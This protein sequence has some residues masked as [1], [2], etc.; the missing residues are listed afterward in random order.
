MKSFFFFKQII[1]KIQLL[2]RITDFRKKREK[3]SKIKIKKKSSESPGRSGIVHRLRP[4]LGDD[5]RLHD[6]RLII[7]SR[8]PQQEKQSARHYACPRDELQRKA[9]LIAPRRSIILASENATFFS[10]SRVDLE[11]SGSR[12]KYR[13]RP[14]GES[15]I[16]KNKGTSWFLF[17]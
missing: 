3:E 15:L 14:G 8:R 5:N 7:R 6:R 4:H 10:F 12:W 13:V 16:K 9:G 17:R 1:Q 11:I 2:S